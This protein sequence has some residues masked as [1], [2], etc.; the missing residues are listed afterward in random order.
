MLLGQLLG[1]VSAEGTFTGAIQS[2]KNDQFATRS[3]HTK[4]IY[5]YINN[6]QIMI[7]FI[8]Y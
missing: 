5:S 7:K 2:L 8:A 6:P 4:L 3:Y 1:D